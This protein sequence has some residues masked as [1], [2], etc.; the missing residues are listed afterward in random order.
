MAADGL[1]ERELGSPQDR[2]V[3]VAARERDLDVAAIEYRH[4]SYFLSVAEELHFGRA[5]TRLFV[6]Q[7]ALSQAIVRLERALGVKLFVRTRHSVELTDAGVELLR[8]ARRLIADLADVVGR[9]RQ[10]GYGVV[11]VLRLGVALMAEDQV[12]PA[13]VAFARECPEIVLDRSAA[14]SER[15]IAE[16]RDGTI[17][18]AL[19][20]PVPVLASPEGVEWEQIRQ[21]LLAILISKGSALAG[22]ESVTLVELSEETFVVNSREL[23]PAALEGLRH[24]CLAHAGFDPKILESTSTLPLGA[25]WEPVAEGAAIALV[26]EAIARTVEAETITAVP[27]RP[28]PLNQLVVAWRDGDRSPVL[29]QFLAFIRTYRDHH[30]WIEDPPA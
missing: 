17:H 27:L 19:G 16:V 3:F 23:A 25:S 1:N 4:L 20:Y 26:P 12:G 9:V 11:G 29:D 2:L 22:R 15:L 14:V 6:S 13:L 30:G 7:P 5:A 18:A 8:H 10:I 24:V 28:P 21:G